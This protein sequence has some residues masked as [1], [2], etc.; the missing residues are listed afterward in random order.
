MTQSLTAAGEQT[1]VG[2]QPSELDLAASVLALTALAAV[3][4]VLDVLG[5]APEF[6]VGRAFPSERRDPSSLLG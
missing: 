5:Q 6:F 1:A 2:A 3:Q 4:P